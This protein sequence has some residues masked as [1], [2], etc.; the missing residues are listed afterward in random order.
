[1][2]MVATFAKV[3][4]I[5]N[6][7][8]RTDRLGSA[9][10]P[11]VSGK[12]SVGTAGFGEGEV[13]SVEGREAEGD[14]VSCATGDCVGIR[15]GFACQFEKEQGVEAV[16]FVMVAAHLNEESG[17]AEPVEVACADVGENAFDG[18]RLSSDAGL[19]RVVVEAGEGAVVEI[20]FH[21]D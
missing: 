7:H 20:N 12:Q 14:K 15:N 13:Q 18:L 10:K 16:S 4:R 19:R 17:T 8:R 3:Y 9:D 21:I 1:M 11:V 6:L 5:K 2:T